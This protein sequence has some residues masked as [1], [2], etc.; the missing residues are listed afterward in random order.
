[1]ASAP[2]ISIA[3]CTYN[4]ERFLR[5]QLESLLGQDHAELEVV[6][7][8]DGSSDGTVAILEAYARRDARVVIHRNAE[9]LGYRRNF[10]RAMSLCRGELVAPCDQDDLW[11][12][13]KL[14]RMAA[15]LGDSAAVY[16]DSELIDAEGRPLGRRMSQLFPMAP[17]DDPAGFFFGNTVSG[18]AML[19]RRVLLERALPIPEGLSHDWWLAFVA[20]AEGGVAW[21][22]EPLVGY[23]QH[24]TTVTDVARLRSGAWRP[25]GRGTARYLATEQRLRAFAG[26]LGGRDGGLSAELLRLWVERRDRFFCGALARLA[27]RHRDRLYALQRPGRV[28]RVREAL[29]LAWGLRL[30]R[31]VQSISYRA[32]PAASASPSLSPRR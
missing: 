4:G 17:I 32:P 6:A 23:R 22:P 19:F 1:V 11:R 3:L 18:H 16:C 7:V 14:R 30:M 26:Y 2:L 31:L 10:E 27:L 21:C 25:P 13:D 29:Q 12:P 9:N 20:A 8:D 28:R 24:D 5:P 15:A